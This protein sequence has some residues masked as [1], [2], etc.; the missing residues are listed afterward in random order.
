MNLNI[1]D[2]LSKFMMGSLSGQNANN[3]NLNFN[4]NQEHTSPNI[5]DTTNF[6]GE[7]HNF[8]VKNYNSAPSYP[9]V[10]FTNRIIQNQ[11]YRQNSYKNTTNNASQNNRQFKN[12]LNGDFIKSFLPLFAPKGGSKTELTSILQKINP[13]MSSILSMLT[14]KDKKENT[15]LNKEEQAESLIDLSDYTEIS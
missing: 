12:F 13:Q 15:K 8:A 10:F 3:Q 11:L 14:K 7:Q 1:M 6:N 4:S 9:D 5:N 2:M